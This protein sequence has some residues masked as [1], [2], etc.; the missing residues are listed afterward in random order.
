MAQDTIELVK[1]L[2]IKRFNLFGGSMGELHFVLP[3]NIPSDLKL[4][5]L[6]IGASSAR[7]RPGIGAY[8]RIEQ[9]YN[10]PELNHPKTIKEQKE[11]LLNS[12]DITLARYLLEH[13]D[14]LNK[15]A[16]II[17]STNYRR[18]FEIFKRQWEAMKQVDFV[19]RLHLI[20]VPT[21]II[22]GDADET[23]PIDE[24]ELLDREIPNTQFHRIPN[25]GH[26]LYIMAFEPVNIINIINEF[27]N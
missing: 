20:K 15:V 26:G 1:H 18:P 10:L 22:H 24:G 3:L 6:V 12:D 8:P 14:E 11:Q 4:E 19:S 5:K 7:V 16:E 9:I 21:L 2:G 17:V 13:P 23:V 27:L 25:V